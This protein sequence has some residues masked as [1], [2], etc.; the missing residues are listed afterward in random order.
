[1]VQL[2]RNQ[3]RVLFIRIEQTP[4]HKML[5]LCLY[6]T[7]EAAENQA[8]SKEKGLKKPQKNN[9]NYLKKLGNITTKIFLYLY[10][11]QKAD[12]IRIICR[13]MRFAKISQKRPQNMKNQLTFRHRCVILFRRDEIRSFFCAVK[14]VHKRYEYNFREVKICVP[15]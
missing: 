15:G 11:V 12:I 10:M 3:F 5:L 2:P 13:K 6:T 7:M 9:N 14:T 1:M 8:F 4:G